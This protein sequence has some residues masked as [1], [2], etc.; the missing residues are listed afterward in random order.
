MAMV[1]N[2]SECGFLAVQR[3]ELEDHFASKGHRNKSLIARL[4]SIFHR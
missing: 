3:Y 2:C 4:L 1:F